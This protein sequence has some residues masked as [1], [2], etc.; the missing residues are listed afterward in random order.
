M[1]IT[2]NDLLRKNNNFDALRLI[3]ALF[4]FLSHTYDVR[5]I[6]QYELLNR[7]TGNYLFSTFGLAIFFSMSGFLV[8]RSLVTSPS[9]KQ[10]L[11]NRFLRIWPAY[12]VN[13]L[14]CI[15]LIGIPFTTLPVLKYIGHQQT[16][17]F[18]F[19]NISLLGSSFY[20][21]GVLNNESI[22]GSI[23]TIPVEVRLY[24]VLLLVYLAAR[25]RFRQLLL[26]LL[27]ALWVAQI[28]TPADWQHAT[29]KLYVIYSIN[30][31]IYF[32]TGACF[33]LYK[34]R[35]PLKLYIWF[36]LFIGWLAMHIWFR[37]LV[38]VTEHPFFVYTI[39]CVA[40]SWYKVPFIKAD[41]SYG[42]YLYATPVQLV[43]Q[44]T[45]GE[46]LGFNT[47]LLLTLLATGGISLLSW[48]LVEKKALS[49]KQLAKRKAVAGIM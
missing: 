15:L 7:L 39:M 13:I 42:V 17:L 45:I 47:F 8:C 40:F 23:W 48:R 49:L 31:G 46:S 25:L 37:P 35:I 41:I 14:F 1:Y 29:F 44:Y 20:L 9:I 43:M 28:L 16:W 6:Q 10:Y 24:L 22:N 27:V 34:E 21:P 18:L 5:N 36:I 32:L 38:H 11:V 30:L 2:E 12:A 33:Y 19:K 4:V 3:A 26:F